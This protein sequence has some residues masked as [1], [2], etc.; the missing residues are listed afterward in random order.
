MLNALKYQIYID[1]SPE[2]VWDV[3]ISPEGTRNTVFG[4]VIQSTF[5]IGAPIAYVGPGNA[6]DET[7]HVYGRVLAFE[8][9]KTLSY[10][11]HP[12]PSYRDNHEEL[13]T[14]VTITLEPA[15]SCTKL[16]LINDE[17]PDNHPSRANT[18][19]GW[20]VILSCIKTYAETGKTLALGW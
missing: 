7:V 11:E 6:G 10:T 18:E 16:T 12:G 20:P 8:P 14:R 5:D 2:K 17:W 1:A 3:L 9:N 19:E 13:E 4:S 15:G